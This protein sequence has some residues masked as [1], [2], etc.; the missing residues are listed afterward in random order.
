MLAWCDEIG[1]NVGLVPS[2]GRESGGM[3]SFR[4]SL[5]NRLPSIQTER[6]PILSHPPSV[7]PWKPQTVEVKCHEPSVFH[8]TC[9]RSFDGRSRHPD[10]RR[11]RGPDRPQAN[12]CQGEGNR[13]RHHRPEQGHRRRARGASGRG[14][15]DRQ[16]NRRRPALHQDRRP[17]Q[18]RHH[19]TRDRFH[20]LQGSR[21]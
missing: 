16:E 3:G 11:H 7:P 5:L 1:A 17:C 18:G 21:R 4:W 9:G 15:G 10:R 13:N 14:P 2:R 8:K 12:H 6:H 20:S 19:G